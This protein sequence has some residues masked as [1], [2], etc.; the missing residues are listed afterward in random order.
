[1]ARYT[2]H[3]I[4]FF[5]SGRRCTPCGLLKSE[6]CNKLYADGRGSLRGMG[7]APPLLCPDGVAARGLR[8]V[9]GVIVLLLV[10]VLEVRSV[11]G[12]RGVMRR[13]GCLAEGRHRGWDGYGADGNWQ[14]SYPPG[15]R[16]CSLFVHSRL[17]PRRVGPVRLDLY[18]TPL[19]NSWYFFHKLSTL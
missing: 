10:R 3:Y 16:Y 13:G 7:G 12:R 11:Y 9:L 8:W 19:K 1:M 6:L 4:L 17:L 14:H 2:P 18:A 15:F 5:Q